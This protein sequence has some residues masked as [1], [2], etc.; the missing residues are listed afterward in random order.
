MSIRLKSPEEIA[1]LREGGQRHAAI[2]KALGEMVEPGISTLDLENEARRLIE[3]GGDEPA[4]LGYT[5]YGAT[6]P[7]PAALCVSVNEEIVHGIPNEHP[8][9]LKEG[10]IVTIDLSLIH[11]G[12]FTDSA[13]TV[14]VGNI[15]EESQKLLKV[16]KDALMAGI[17]AIEVGG[18]IGDIGAT[19]AAAVAPSGFSLAKNLVGHGVGYEIHEEPYV[20]NEGK[21]GEGETLVPGMVF[22]VEP[23]VCVGKGAWKTL[24]DGYTIVTRDGKRSAHFEHTVAITEKGPIILTSL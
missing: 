21:A 24:K 4:H 22:A 7:F 6:R 19:I 1:T 17:A 23:M 15:D 2:L 13:I 5:P 3:E 14:P 20:P 9:I 10:D 16:T 11:K 12:L 8:K 18:H